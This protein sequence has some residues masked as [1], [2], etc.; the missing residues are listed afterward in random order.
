[1]LNSLDP[2]DLLDDHKL[3][4]WLQ[5]AE[6]EGDVSFKS[7]YVS[8]VWRS[9]LN[10][11]LKTEAHFSSLHKVIKV[12]FQRGVITF[13][14]LFDHIVFDAQLGGRVRWCSTLQAVVF[15][16]LNENPKVLE[17]N[18]LFWNSFFAH[19]LLG[20]DL[21]EKEYAGI[22]ELTYKKRCLHIIS[23]F[24]SELEKEV[25]VTVNGIKKNCIR[26]F[27]DSIWDAISPLVMMIRRA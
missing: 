21:Q 27:N 3:E 20:Q 23:W 11:A 6:R 18:K 15:D 7:V 12:L 19:P 5:F 1:M 9:G 14:N 13:S 22:D 24:E 4:G 10:E 16:M 17:N 2:L 26:W 8:S 25:V